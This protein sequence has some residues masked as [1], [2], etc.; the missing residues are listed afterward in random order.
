MAKSLE[1]TDAPRRLKVKM[2]GDF[3]SGKTQLLIAIERFVASLGM[4]AVMNADGHNL[5]VI[6]TRSARVKLYWRNHGQAPAD[7][8]EVDE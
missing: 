2:R 7:E 5:D 4:S 6:S 1:I 3:R 8:D